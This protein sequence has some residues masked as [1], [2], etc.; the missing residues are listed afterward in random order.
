VVASGEEVLP[1]LMEIPPLFNKESGRKLSVTRF[2]FGYCSRGS[3]F[4][5]KYCW[6]WDWEKDAGNVIYTYV[7]YMYIQI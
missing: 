2:G 6:G 4:Q 3:H 7:L 5:V 1:P